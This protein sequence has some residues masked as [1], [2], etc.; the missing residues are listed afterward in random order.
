MGGGLVI[1][2]FCGLFRW[3]LVFCVFGVSSAG[4]VGCS[5]SRVELGVSGGYRRRPGG[6][7]GVPGVPGGSWNHLGHL[8]GAL[9]V[10]WERPSSSPGRPAGSPS[11][12]GGSPGG[13]GCRFYVPVGPQS[14]RSIP[15]R[16][17]IA[18]GPLSSYY[19]NFKKIFGGSGASRRRL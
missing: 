18:A 1:W 3:L 15:L 2:S 14:F 13:P 17:W 11:G 10:S 9:E 12:P 8:G 6:S 16:S 7:W 4:W 5:R 19:K